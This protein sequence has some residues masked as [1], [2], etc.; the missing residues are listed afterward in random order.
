M[1]SGEWTRIRSPDGR[2]NIPE[3]LAEFKSKHEALHRE[4]T[5]AV[6]TPGYVKAPWRDRDNALTDEYRARLTELG[7]PRTEPLLASRMR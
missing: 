1:S 3:L 5:A 2:R 4:W 7:Y 6:G